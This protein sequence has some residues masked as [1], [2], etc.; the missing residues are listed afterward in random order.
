[1]EI[2]TTPVRWANFREKKKFYTYEDREKR[3]KKT[4]VTR[5]DYLTTGK[6]E[7]KNYETSD[8]LSDALKGK[9]DN[10]QFRLY[11][12]E[13]LSRDVIEVLGAQLDIEP[14]FFREHII[15]YAWCNIRD[16]WFDPP[17]LNLVAKQQRWLQLRFVTAR[18]FTTPESF[19]RGCQEAESFNVLRRPDD[20]QN[21]RAMWDTKEAIVGLTRSRASFWLKN[22]ETHEKGAVGK[23][24]YIWKGLRCRSGI[25]ITRF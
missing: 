2:S 9:D 6:V 7:A 25:A 19:K 15:D 11:V 17:N 3:W 23:C 12:V 22:G 8:A 24:G 21:N 13:D 5:L 14:A 20:D 10:S 4:N 16:R 18:Y 1:M